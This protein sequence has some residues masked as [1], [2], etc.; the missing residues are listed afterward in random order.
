[1]EFGYCGT[2]WPHPQPSCH[3]GETK[4]IAFGLV[5]SIKL[6]LPCLA[7]KLQATSD[8]QQARPE[9][10]LIKTADLLLKS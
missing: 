6:R 8:R 4:H 3:L 2:D 5:A 1:M 9:F 10:P 7:Q